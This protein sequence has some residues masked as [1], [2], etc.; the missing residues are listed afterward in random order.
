MNYTIYWILIVVSVLGS[1][2]IVLDINSAEEADRL[3]MVPILLAE[4]NLPREMRKAE[5]WGYQLSREFKKM[6]NQLYMAIQHLEQWDFR[7]QL[8]FFGKIKRF[9]Y[10]S[11]QKGSEQ[12]GKLEAIF[13]ELGMWATWEAVIR[14]KFARADQ[15][16]MNDLI[17]SLKA[18]FGLTV[19]DF[20]TNHETRII[21]KHKLAQDYGL[22]VDTL[23]DGFAFVHV[24][25]EFVSSVNKVLDPCICTIL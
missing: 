18:K 8:I 21:I 17:N 25:N 12:D 22:E 5:F 19:I 1:S 15:K 2:T 20:A 7:Y 10:A 11:C 16:L 6:A 4:G 13:A 23:S 3:A 24:I 9:Q 14:R